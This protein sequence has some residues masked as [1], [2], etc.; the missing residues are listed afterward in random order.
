LTP[1][2]DGISLHLESRPAG[3]Q[4]HFGH[5][6]RARKKIKVEVTS[7][8]EQESDTAPSPAMVEGTLLGV[9]HLITR[10]KSSAARIASRT[11]TVMIFGETGTGKEVLARYIHAHS[12]RAARPFIP[13]D[14]AAISESLFE[15]QLFGHV[16]GAF[17]EANRESLGFIRAA[18]GGT[19]FLDEIGELDLSLQAKLLPV[20][21]EK[22]M[23]PVGDTQ[24]QPVDIR[25]IC[26]TNRDLAAMVAAGAFRQDLYFRLQVFTLSLP[27]LRARPDDL[28]PL[29]EYCL[30]QLAELSGSDAKQLSVPAAEAL[31]RH[32]WPG[33]VRELFNVIEHA[34]VLS[35]GDVIQVQ[36]LPAPLSTG[37]FRAHSLQEFNLEQVERR[38]I[39]EALK[40]CRYNRSA[41]CQLLGLEL[42]RLNRRIT[43]LTI[44][45]PS[46][47]GP[48][49]N[50]PPLPSPTAA[51]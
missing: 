21:V 35:D 36:D 17:P 28:I 43:S 46:R 38:T 7:P 26:S 6:A 44:E 5:R 9:S 15:S 34:H 48:T 12:P 42:R 2:Q 22:R 49:R 37:E 24:P 11:S 47:R 16:K 40:R 30:K 41:A 4:A 14:C 31:L 13:V 27:P 50:T 33:N 8:L 23:I 51:F 45:I 25:L 3:D 20:L 18:N 32:S 10:L 1:A 19:L 29:S 39:V